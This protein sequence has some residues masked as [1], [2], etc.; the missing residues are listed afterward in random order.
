MGLAFGLGPLTL[1]HIPRSIWYLPIAKRD[2]WRATW[3]VATIGVTL[4]LTTIKLA[5]LLAPQVRASF[6]L[7]SLVLSSAYDFAY[8]GV[9]CGLIILA[10]RPQP[11]N[12]P[13]RRASGM[14][15]GMA[16]GILPLGLS[17][18][19]VGNFAVGSVLPTHWND[20]TVLSAAVLVVALGLTVATC[21]HSP[22]PPSPANR[23]SDRPRVQTGTPR[24]E[25]VGLTGLPHLLVHEAAWTLALGG[26]ML[27]GSMLVVVLANLWQSSEGTTALARSLLLRLDGSAPPMRNEVMDAVVP[28]IG[29]A[30][31]VASLLAR[32]PAMLRHLRVLPLGASRLNALLIA[33]P[34]AIWLTAWAGLLALHYVVIGRGVASYHGAALLGLIGL[35]ALVQALTLRLSNVFRTFLFAMSVG[36][37]PFLGLVVESPPRVPFLVGVGLLTAAVLLNHRSLARKSTYTPIGRVLGVALTP[38]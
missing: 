5:A 17:V 10:T 36:V 3:A 20:L 22:V 21:F 24:F 33:W 25:L 32:F 15:K 1:W 11:M 38:R 19:M 35:S 9:G 27:A 4:L 7:G 26:A 31:F 13:A 28:L 16:E 23:I 12:G 37:A 6:G 2:I 34:A 18:V 14:L 29:F 30:V 8:T